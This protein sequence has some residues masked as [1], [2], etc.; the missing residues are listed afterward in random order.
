MACVPMFAICMDYSR[1]AN[2]GFDYT[3]QITLIFIGSLLAGS[4]SGFIAESLAYLG[5]F[6]IVSVL[7]LT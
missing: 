5:V 4:L 3:L 1:Q 6:A 7:S 2:A